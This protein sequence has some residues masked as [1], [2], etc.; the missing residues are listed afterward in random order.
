MTRF[1]GSRARLYIAFALALLAA[2]LTERIIS[3][4]VLSRVSSIE[5][6]LT[7]EGPVELRLNYQRPPAARGFNA[8]RQLEETL[9]LDG[10][11]RL[12][13]SMRDA[14]AVLFLLTLE[15]KQPL[16]LHALVF[17]SHYGPS[18][19]LTGEEI[20]DYF[21]PGAEHSRIEAS[22]G[23][24][25][26]SPARGTASLVSTKKIDFTNGYLQFGL[27]AIVGVL[28]FF[29]VLRFDPV[30]VPSLAQL[31]P[32]LGA[33]AAKVHS[34][35]L[36]GLRGLAALSVVADHTWGWFTGSG[37][38]G[39]WIFFALSG[40]LLAIPFVRHPELVFDKDRLQHYV[41]R[42][43]ARIV[44]M[45]YTMLFI[46]FLASGNVK[47]AIPHFL[48]I[49]GDGHYWTIPQEMLFYLVLPLVMIVMAMLVRVRYGLAVFV[50]IISSLWLLFN[51]DLVSFMINGRPDGHVTHIGWFL[52]GIC[53]SYLLNHKPFR[54]TLDVRRTAFE[55]PLGLA[56]VAVL[57]GVFVFGSTTIMY[58]WL[59]HRIYPSI[60]FKVYFGLASAF[61]VFAAVYARNSVYGS[62]L[63]FKP[64]RSF[65][66]IGYSAYLIHPLLLAIIKKLSLF[67][68]GVPIQG[69][70]LFAAT[71]VVTWVVATFTYNLIEHPFLFRR[72]K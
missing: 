20:L 16:V 59:G 15:T 8:R 63:R 68:L 52:A 42:R 47:W 24:I 38:A 2:I 45:Y 72:D 34:L 53:V 50:L 28:L 30:R 40:Y 67:Y 48:F 4:D 56:A 64:L 27:P 65:G 44:P 61:L 11:T 35:E 49:Q 46:S 39:V 58:A 21:R 3:Y 25:E 51:N 17:N 10:K 62:L 13:M 31:N 9:M 22:A 33:D 55:K 57:T 14:L 54:D 7:G 66:I 1:S 12:E 60:E 18:R 5:L 71:T 37:L 43:I 41:F 26:I 36:D 70:A 29:S 69:F 23:G 6:V 19:R 32:P